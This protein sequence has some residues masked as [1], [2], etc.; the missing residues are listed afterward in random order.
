MIIY[1]IYQSINLSL[2]Y[3][4]LAGMDFEEDDQ[5]ESK[6]VKKDVLNDELMNTDAPAKRRSEFLTKLHNSKECVFKCR[7]NY[8][9][10]CIVQKFG[11]PNIE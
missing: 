4:Y 10:V 1:L 9:L 7:V 3:F 5:Q 6:V 11:R 8:C 2:T